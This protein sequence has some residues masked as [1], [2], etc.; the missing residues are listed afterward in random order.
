MFDQSIRL[1]VK[2]A[3]A[4][5]K[6]PPKNDA[7]D[8]DVTTHRKNYYRWKWAFVAKEI[9]SFNQMAQS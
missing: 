3:S 8:V 7:G 2:A 4:R 5:E 6:R 9:Y 1:Y